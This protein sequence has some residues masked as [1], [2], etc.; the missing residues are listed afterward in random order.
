MLVFNKKKNYKE[1]PYRYN[2]GFVNLYVHVDK[3]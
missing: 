1:K 3:S 2:T